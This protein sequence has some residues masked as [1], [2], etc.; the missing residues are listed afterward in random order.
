MDRV[1]ELARRLDDLAFDLVFQR[2]VDRVWRA[3]PGD[4][5]QLALG[6]S[7]GLVLVRALVVH[8]EGRFGVQQVTGASAA[9]ALGTMLYGARLWHVPAPSGRNPRRV[10]AS[11]LM[12]R[13]FGLVMLLVLLVLPVAMAPWVPQLGLE[14]WI[15]LAGNAVGM[16]SLY[17]EGCDWPA[18]PAC[19]DARLAGLGRAGLGRSGRTGG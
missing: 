1:Y 12:A 3:P 2:L 19:Q 17:M 16:A 13:M 8:H 15:T 10:E 7:V 6:G 11:Y 9:L 18:P 14:Y 4:F 5:A